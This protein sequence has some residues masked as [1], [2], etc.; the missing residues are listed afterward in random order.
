[1]HSKIGSRGSVVSRNSSSA[2]VF[3]SALIAGG[4][5]G[6]CDAAEL[7]VPSKQYPTI[8]SAINAAVDGDVVVIA[9]GEYNVGDLAI[10]DVAVTIRGAGNSSNTILTGE[11]VQVLGGT[12][13]RTI[14]SITLRGF[15]GYAA[16]HVNGANV[17]LENVT[18]DANGIHGVFL[19]TNATLVSRD[20]RITKNGRGGFGYVNCFW[21]AENCTFF[22]NGFSKAYGGAVGFHIGSGCAFTNCSFIANSATTG[23]AIGLSFSGSRVFDGCFFQDNTAGVGDVWWTEFGATGTLKNSVLC[24]HSLS[25]IL[26]GWIDGGG[27]QFFPDGCSEPC[28]ADF[29]ADGTVNAADLGV[30]L[31]FWGTDGS[32]F[33]GVDLD[34]DGIVGAADLATLLSAWG[35]CPE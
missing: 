26:G 13:T 2:V 11:W 14:E 27:N 15:T 10:P 29:I 33:P 34:N 1:M 22:Q 5:A 6:V 16:L 35:P 28:P 20:C 17:V 12:R 18:L 3:A 30:M 23:G 8:Q 25:D 4:V 32:G 31:N 21:T 7:N 19:N 9:A 24:G